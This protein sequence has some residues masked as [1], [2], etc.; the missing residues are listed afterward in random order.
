ME[1]PGLDHLDSRAIDNRFIGVSSSGK[2]ELDR[3]VSKDKSDHKDDAESEKDQ[4]VPVAFRL[5]PAGG[6]DDKNPT[7]T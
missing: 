4:N 6:H 1:I 5:E 7:A 2:A 3:L